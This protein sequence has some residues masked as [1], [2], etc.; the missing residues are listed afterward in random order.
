MRQIDPVFGLEKL[1]SATVAS[2][3]SPGA[4]SVIV[5][6]LLVDVK[7]YAA[8]AMLSGLCGQ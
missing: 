1:S 7:A 4:Q 6:Q 2:D 5:D 3:L 8:A